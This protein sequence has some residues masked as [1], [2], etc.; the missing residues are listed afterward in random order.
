MPCPSIGSKLYHAATC[1]GDD[2]FG[3]S[4][5]LPQNQVN[6]P[7]APDVYAFT[8]TMGNQL[9][10]VAT[11]VKQGVGKDGKS[12]GVKCAFGHLA[13][14]VDGLGEAGDGAVVLFERQQTDAT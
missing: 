3:L 8:S 5:L 4:L 14:F 2:R 12:G 11:G 7:A 6:R 1:K 13:L 9:F 10:I